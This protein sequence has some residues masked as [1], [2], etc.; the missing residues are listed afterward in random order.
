R[1]D[2]A[3]EL[4]LQAVERKKRVLG[5]EHP[6]T[7]RSIVKQAMILV[8]QGRLEEAEELRVLVTKTMMKLL[9]ED[10]DTLTSVK[11]HTTILLEQTRIMEAIK[12]AKKSIPLPPRV[13]GPSHPD[14][15]FSSEEITQWQSE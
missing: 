9:S 7:L 3:E 15:L 2:E 4:I 6:D 11:N 12:S 14:T 10:P 1:L 8:S 13:L 5:E